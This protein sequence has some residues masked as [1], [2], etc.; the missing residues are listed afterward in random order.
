MKAFL[1]WKVAKQPVL[2]SAAVSPV[3]TLQSNSWVSIAQTEAVMDTLAEVEIDREGKFKY[4]LVKIWLANGKEEEE[5]GKL[6]VRGTSEAEFH[7]DIM[8]KVK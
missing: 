3:T 2:D 8:A 1:G 6:I 5:E 7:P 4:I